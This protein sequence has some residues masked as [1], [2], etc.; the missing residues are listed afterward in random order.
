MRNFKKFSLAGASTIFDSAMVVVEV[1]LI[2]RVI[3]GVELMGAT[4]R[5]VSIEI[6]TV[7]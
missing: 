4:W 3:I 2:G 7:T 6:R 1:A 5:L